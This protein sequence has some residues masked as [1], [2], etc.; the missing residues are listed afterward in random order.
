M[1]PNTRRIVELAWTRMLGLTDGT[2]DRSGVVT[3]ADPDRLMYL[4]L[5]QH[6]VLVG[7]EE[8][9]GR[10]AQLDETDL[11][12]G[13]AL[14]ALASRGRL[15]GTCLLAYQDDYQAD[16]RLRTVPVSDEPADVAAMV[17]TCPPDDAAEV[18]L[19]RLEWSVVTLDEAGEAT[20]GAG[21]DE[22][23]HLVAH[24]GVLTPPDQRRHGHG[25]LAAAL[26]NNEALDRGLI[27]QWRV[28]DSNLAS[29]ALARR[30]GFEVAGSQTTVLLAD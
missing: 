11:V 20:A 7:P 27:P 24:L 18:D 29:R 23:Q 25:T 21:F 3:V 5:W 22:W 26:A 28:R 2:L 1:D 10:A 14:L 16:P 13:A 17:R 9:L 12:A 15:L 8:L 19:E 30:L 4:R 6:R